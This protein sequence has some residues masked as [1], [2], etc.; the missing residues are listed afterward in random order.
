MKMINF[1]RFGICGALIAGAALMLPACA[2]DMGDEDASDVSSVFTEGDD[3][4]ELESSEE[5]VGTS[6]EALTSTTFRA[7][8][9]NWD[10]LLYADGSVLVPYAECRT[11]SGSWR[12]TS[13]GRGF[14]GGDLANCNGY[15]RCGAC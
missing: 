14:C 5:L 11:A 6:S 7:T 4:T 13:W 9:M 2:A 15:L 3:L 10:L 8:C 1:N 12:V